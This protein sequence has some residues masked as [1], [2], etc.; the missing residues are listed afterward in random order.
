MVAFFAMMLVSTF[1]VLTAFNALTRRLAQAHGHR[2]RSLLPLYVSAP[3]Y[4]PPDADS[5]PAIAATES[6]DVAGDDLGERLRARSRLVF[7]R[8][9]LRSIVVDCM[10]V[11][12]END[13]L[14]LVPTGSP[15]T[16][17][18]RSPDSGWFTLCIETMLEQWA[19]EEKLVDVEIALGEG[20]PRANLSDGSSRVMLDLE[21]AAGLAA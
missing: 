13:Q 3:L 8:P 19:E 18:L 4:T 16:L 6:D 7:A 12:L 2:S 10:L 1:L 17:R 20:R 14:G 11:E 9:E 5:A 21:A 15:F